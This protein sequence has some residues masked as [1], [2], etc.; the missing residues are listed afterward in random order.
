VS[1]KLREALLAL[2]IERK[3]TKDEILRMYLNQI[4]FGEGAY[5]IEAAARTYFDKPARDLDLL[6][7]ATLA[8]LPK[9]PNGYSPLDY[10]DRARKRR[11]VV[12]LTMREHGL[13][14]PAQYESLTASPLVTHPGSGSEQAGGYFTEEVRKY[15]ESHYGSTELYRG[16]L[17]IFTTLDIELQRAAERALESRFSEL[18]TS[19]SLVHSRNDYLAARGRGLDPE[20]KYLQGAIVAM[21]PRTGRVL[22]MVGGRSF[23]ESRFNRAV[24]AKRQPGSCFKPFVYLTAIQKGIG[25][26]EI[27]L[28]TPLV[29]DMGEGREPWK[30][31]N[32]SQTFS[33]PVS[34]RAALAKSLNIPS[35][36]LLQ[37]VGAPAVIANAH[38]MGIDSRLEPVLS[39]ALGTSEVSLLELVR[40]YGVLANG[41]ISS[42]PYFIERI[43]DRRGKVLERASEYHEEALDPQ[44]A[45]LVT[46]ML[47]SALDWGTGHNARDLYGIRV[48][49]AGKTGTTDD[50]GDGWFV[51]YTPDLVVGVWGGFD[52]RRPIGLAG[53]YI[54]LPP[55]C[56]VMRQYVATH[57]GRDFPQP[58]GIEAAK[59]C[60]DS[61]KLATSQC[62]RVQMEIFTQRTLPKRD[63]D[64]HS[65]AGA[66]ERAAE[67]GFGMEGGSGR[68]LAPP[69][70]PVAPAVTPTPQP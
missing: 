66:G 10:P 62:P 52:E 60:V 50:L 47:E 57:T 16:E 58:A 20:P 70:A 36:K 3:Y 15:L 49:A 6:E 26:S 64:L 19:L 53:S 42:R 22:A 33:G 1:R 27:L 2:R 67:I 8:G 68:D 24:Q 11:N 40:A 34:V 9:N 14:E 32:Y 5:G 35:I 30:P 18:E 65:V 23:R 46:S 63:C 51:G 61:G 45:Y 55:W 17:R 69:P 48:P 56:D 39:L 7:C 12:L 25:P 59:I 4:Y 41:G 29:I 21:D 43:E 38:K 13:I 28:D 54:A 44:T 37:Q 31:Q